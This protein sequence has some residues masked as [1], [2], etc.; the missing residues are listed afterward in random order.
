MVQ[1]MRDM[2]I[3][4]YAMR[5]GVTIE[6]RHIIWFKCSEC[7]DIFSDMLHFEPEDFYYCV[8]RCCPNCGKKFVNGM[9]VVE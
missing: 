9:Q 2:E 7:Y 8:P 6:K 4:P 5:V 3:K 1:E